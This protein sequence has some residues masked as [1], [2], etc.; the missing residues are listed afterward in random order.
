M[1]VRI[2][3]YLAQNGLCSRRSA[4][5]LIKSGKVIINDK[6]AKLGDKI[7]TTKDKILVNNKLIKPQEDLV[8]YMLNKPVGYVSTT[9]D[10]HASRMITDLVPNNPRVFPVGRLDR[11]SEGL[12]ILTNDGEITNL[13]THP[14]FEHEKEYKIEAVITH[15]LKDLKAV[16]NRLNRF[17]IGMIIDGKNTLPTEAKN[18]EFFPPKLVKFDVTLK[19]GRKRQI[20]R[21]CELIGLD[22]RRLQRIRIN[23]LRL[24]AL[25]VGD[26]KKIAR[27]DILG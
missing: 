5:T 1:E 2:N 4:D 19:E 27:E 23:K 9:K 3:K 16:K 15:G 7:D 6:K 18:I 11:Q 24:E 20:R 21:M 8:Y 26:F 14:K 22:V 10:D 17:K 12:I 25:K 13:L